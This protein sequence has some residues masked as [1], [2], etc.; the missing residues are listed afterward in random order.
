M[1]KVGIQSNRILLMRI[2]IP[3][4]ILQAFQ[5]GQKT[6]NGLKWV[7]QSVNHPQVAYGGG[8]QHDTAMYL[9]E[10]ALM[11]R[12]L[13]MAIDSVKLLPGWRFLGRPD[14]LYQ[15]MT[16]GLCTAERPVDP[17]IDHVI[18]LEIFIFFDE[19]VLSRNLP[20]NVSRPLTEEV[21]K[22]VW[23]S[24]SEICRNPVLEEPALLF[25]LNWPIVMLLYHKLTQVGHFPH[26][27]VA[28]Y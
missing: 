10:T 26:T 9:N 17:N 12:K 2:L 25:N 21:I 1:E 24:L 20:L 18:I 23:K 16:S 6:W 13:E 3:G 11:G 7:Y 15:N 5:F 19:I 22:V 14:C 8:G 27:I 28:D 4:S